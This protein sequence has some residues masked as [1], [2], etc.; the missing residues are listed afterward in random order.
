MKLAYNTGRSGH[1]AFDNA[2][3]GLEIKFVIKVYTKIF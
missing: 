1:F 3:V 2:Y